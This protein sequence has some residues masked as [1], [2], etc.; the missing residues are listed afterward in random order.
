MDRPLRF[1][2]VTTFYPPYSF[3]GDGV[4]VK[5]LSHELAARGHQVTVIHNAD[6]FR[7]LAGRGPEGGYDDPSNVSVQALQSR[8]PVLSL[9]AAHQTGTPALYASELRRLLSQDFDV[10]HFHNVSLMGGPGVLAL[11]DALKLYT[12]HEYWLV[13]PTHGLFRFG[14]T[15]CSK[16]ICSLCT[17]SYG[18]PPQ[19][20][21]YTN[22]LNH[23]ARHV[24]LFLA[25]SRFVAAKHVELGLKRP[26]THLPNFTPSLESA[27]PSAAPNLSEPYFL[28]VGRLEWLKG[29][30][31]LIPVFRRF[32]R[33]QLR[34]AGAGSCEARFRSL[35]RD[36]P[37]IQFLGWKS[38]EELAPLLS[39]A[40]ALIFPSVNF[41]T[42]GLVTLEA[43]SQETPVLGR[44]LGSLP[45]AIRDSGGGFQYR[46]DEELIH[47][48]EMLLDRPGLR[49]SL[50]QNARAAW[51]R[52]WSPEVHMERYLGLVNELLERRTA[53]PGAA[54]GVASP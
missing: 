44:D 28:F 23:A 8:T 26:I 36:C 3:G 35:A 47:A 53:H 11:G 38:R 42:S 34:I 2:M 32:Q 39:G 45:E 40:I 52:L 48:M 14:R 49:R 27:M 22:R 20:W 25:P 15:P 12:M 51:A 16:R 54:A 6:A 17:L 19:L 18:R 31:T 24:D 13:C 9:L 29:L 7:V 30:Q 5:R 43:F 1:A 37:N 4:F 41:E 10:I 46:N 21:R 33:A 50:G